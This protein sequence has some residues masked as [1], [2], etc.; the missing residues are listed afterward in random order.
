MGKHYC[1]SVELEEWW[2][3]WLATSTYRVYYVENN[4]GEQR[5]RIEFISKGDERNWTKM[6]DMLYSV[7][8]GIAKNFR[9]KTDE[10]YHN[11]ANEA[12]IRLIDK[13]VEGKLNYTPRCE[14][15]SPVFNLVT[16]TVHRILCSYKN[17]IKRERIRHS[18]HVMKEVRE[19][20][21]ELL[22][23]VRDLYTD[24]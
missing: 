20:A 3:G 14:G 22:S 4:R 24:Q 7:C 9:P 17:Q 19:K 12:M 11:L 2:A 5:K 13:I 18:K 16:T 15:G 8:L 1:D 10:E 23:S 6:T 21:P